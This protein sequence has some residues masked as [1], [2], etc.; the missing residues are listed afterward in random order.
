M[1]ITL[2]REVVTVVSFITFIGILRYALHPANKDR[3]E[4]AGHVVLDDD[5]GAPALTPGQGANPGH[6]FE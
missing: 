3:F 6:G 4:E 1:D 5:D 2:L